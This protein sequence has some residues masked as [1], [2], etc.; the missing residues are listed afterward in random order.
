MARRLG[1]PATLLHVLLRGFAGFWAP[2]SL[3]QRLAAS[4]EAVI[5][6]EQVGDPA[7]AFWAYTDLALAAFG[8][9]DRDES[10]RAASRRDELADRLGQP[11]L[12]WVRAALASTRALLDG[13]LEDAERL[14]RRAF[15]LATSSGQP[16]AAGLIAIQ[17]A[18]V[19]SHQGRDRDMVPLLEKTVA[20]ASTLSGFRALL[21]RACLDSGEEWRAKEI[22][23]DVV[24]HGIEA[25]WDVNWLIVTCWW[26]DVAIRLGHAH[27]AQMLYE[28][29]EPWHA[30]V[31]IIAS[32]SES[33]VCHYL[34]TLAAMLGNDARADEHF[35][36]ALAVHSALQA[37][38]HVARTQLELGRMLLG[39]GAAGDVPR[40]RELL[41]DA[42]STASHFGYGSIERNA[43][44]LLDPERRA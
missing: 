33:A 20:Q 28:R 19:R 1:E 31:A 42:Q 14:A 25:P 7:T 8:A 37:P 24:E 15:D 12:D 18:Q 23:D 26:S 44:I 29:L 40:A 2:D 38:F 17:L 10:D 11:A 27:A 30:H 16:D 32:A 43:A 39:R 35:S 5:L 22:F 36:A 3:A 4:R 34:G 41:N 13:D 6:A 9:A 21:A